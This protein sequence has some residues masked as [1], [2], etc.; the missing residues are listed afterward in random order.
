MLY[1]LSAFLRRLFDPEN[2]SSKTAKTKDTVI[3]TA[4]PGD[5]RAK[6]APL[7]SPKRCFS[8]SSGDANDATPPGGGEDDAVRQ[9]GARPEGAAPLGG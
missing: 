2:A 8:A 1:G 9:G 5:A 6:S 3:T 4:S 7:P